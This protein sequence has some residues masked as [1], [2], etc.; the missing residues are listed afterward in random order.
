MF[1]K[2]LIPTLKELILLQIC[3]LHSKG[4]SKVIFEQFKLF[5]LTSL[6]ISFVKLVSFSP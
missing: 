1:F 5:S 4:E 3:F 6:K 2:S